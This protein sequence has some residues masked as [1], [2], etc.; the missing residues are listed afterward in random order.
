LLGNGDVPITWENQARREVSVSEAKLQIVY[1]P[2]AS[3]RSPISPGST[4][5]RTASH[6]LKAEATPDE[7]F[8]AHAPEVDRL[9]RERGYT[10][11][12]VVHIC[13]GNPNWSALR[14]KFIAEHTHSE[15][16]VRFFVEGSGALFLHIGDKILEVIGEKN[17][18]LSV[19]HGVPHWFDGGPEGNFTCIRLFTDQEAWAANYTG[20]KLSDT[21]PKYKE[22]A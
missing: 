20:D 11:G 8:A 16:E 1:S 12:D 15:D 10:N 13:P 6:P 14:H 9:E 2:I 21:F 17:D 18:L 3:W 4:A 7:F 19:P 22:A 5:Q